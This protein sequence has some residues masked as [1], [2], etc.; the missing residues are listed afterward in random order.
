MLKNDFDVV[1]RKGLLLSLPL[2]NSDQN[3]YPL[4]GG[5]QYARAMIEAAPSMD[6]VEAVHGRW[7]V[8]EDGNFCNVKCSVCRKDY[9]C[10]YGMLQL[11][12]FSFCPNCG[13]KMDG[14]KNEAD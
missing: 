13:A 8:D 11:Q 5:I 1:S 3:G 4:N 9:A 7:I 2:F 14:G 6:A 10:H 12:N